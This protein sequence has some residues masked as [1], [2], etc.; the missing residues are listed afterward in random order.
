M[1][2]WFD[3]YLAD[4]MALGRGEIVDVRRILRYY[5]VPLIVSTDARSTTLTD[6]T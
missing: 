5:A 4:F 3:S 6:E 2:R 1:K